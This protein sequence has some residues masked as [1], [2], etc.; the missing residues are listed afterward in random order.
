MAAVAQVS[1]AAVSAVSAAVAAVVLAVAAEVVAVAIVMCAVLLIL[2]TRAPQ[3]SIEVI[4]CL[5]C[6]YVV[7]DV[8]ANT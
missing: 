4:L 3:I 2:R 7:R 5:A 8:K 6:L 1:T